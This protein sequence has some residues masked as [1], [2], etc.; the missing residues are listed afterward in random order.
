MTTIRIG[1]LTA[2]RVLYLDAAID[3]EPTGL[4]PD[5]V[6]AVTWAEPTW[7]EGGQVRAAACAWTVRSGG[8]TVV[9]DPLGNIDDILHD[10]ATTADHQAAVAATFDGAGIPIESVDTVVLSHIE[11]VGF[12]AVREGDSAQGGWRPFFPN[13][14]LAMSDRA[15]DAFG[16]EPLD[17]MVTA[18]IGALIDA[19]LVDTFADGDDVVPGLRAEWTGAHNPGHVALHADA[20][21]AAGLTFVG[22]L[23]VTGVHLAAPCP[24]QHFDPERAWSYVRAWAESGR[25][26]AGPL[27]PSPGAGRWVDDRLEPVRSA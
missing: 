3:P 22:H 5:E 20:P 2:T 10:P 23:A 11:S 24:P 19:G 26:L 1:D 6:R 9:I 4:T 17:P 15:L 18:A 14:R 7:A 12:A 16:S 13:A 21:G 8:R 25:V 27:W